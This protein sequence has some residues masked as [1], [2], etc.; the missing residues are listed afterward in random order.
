MLKNLIAMIKS[1]VI[2]TFLAMLMMLTPVMSQQSS[3]SKSSEK[4][5]ERGS[6]RASVKVRNTNLI[7]SAHIEFSPQYYQTGIVFV[8]SR[9]NKGAVDK[10][11][12]EPF[13]ELYFADTDRNGMP[14][15]PQPFS[16]QINSQTHEGPVAFSRDMKKMFFTRNNL[17]NGVTKANSQ[18]KVGMKIYEATRGY[19][20]W[21]NVKELSFNND[22]FNFVHP[23]LSP[24]ESKLYFSSNMTGGY[25]G[26]DLYVADKS[27]DGWGPPRNLGPNI[28]TDKN[29]V[30]PF[31]HE[32]GNLFFSSNGHNSMGG[33]DIFT[34]YLEGEQE[35]IN[36]GE[37]FN[38]LTDDL[39]F[40]L[41]KDGNQGFFASDREGGF[42]KDDIYTFDAPDG[43]FGVAEAITWNAKISVTDEATNTGITGAQVRILE[44]SEDGFL[45]GNELYDVE[46]VPNP[47]NPNELLLKLVR[48][49]AES[50]DVPYLTT[51]AVG[52]TFA[53]MEA[54]KQFI[55]MVTKEGYQNGEMMFA[56][57]NLSEDPALS[58]PLK[59]ADCIKFKGFVE[60]EGTGTGV[61]DA[62]VTIVNNDDGSTQIVK[63]DD[64][65]T[66]EYC[67]PPNANFSISVEKAGFSSGTTQASTAGLT[68][69]SEIKVEVPLRVMDEKSEAGPVDEGDLIVLQNIY[70]DFG[71]SAIRVGAARELDALATLMRKYPSMEIEL[72]AH[73]DCRGSD[74]ANMQ[75]SLARAESAK[76]YLVSN[77]NIDASRIKAFG[78][79]ESQ[80]RNHCVDGVE[81]SE[82]DHEFN[83][84]SEV[85]ITKIDNPIKVEYKVKKP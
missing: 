56:T 84:R 74:E 63:T 23:S 6:K 32:S 21:E 79:G 11:I 64:N 9:H 22:E 75:L 13:F 65:G 20:D 59:K 10:K 55:I 29:E 34:V 69:G 19:F 68:P 33:L 70:Y 52:E 76:R 25:G 44:R 66:F 80:P 77:G 40:I 24:D 81:C 37:P 4:L 57:T 42:G 50:L 43:I 53:E 8:T 26:M 71:K 82:E 30:F 45:E 2:L 85:R 1:N 16:L 83:R 7:N 36:L 78:Y 3:K 17:K 18:G 48:R 62:V 46:M 31:I 28:N 14:L 51:N 38:S 15:E 73:T 67:L 58:I 72:I 61:S 39:G 54:D 60:A 12:S 47:G 5:Y 27:A 41:N 35:V 49:N